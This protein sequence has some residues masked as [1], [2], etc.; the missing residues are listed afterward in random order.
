MKNQNIILLFLTLSILG[1][2][3]AAYLFLE[4]SNK[5]KIIAIL[6][7]LGMLASSIGL[8]INLKDKAKLNN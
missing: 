5:D 2:D 3:L 1:I 7:G 4:L 8:I 6:V